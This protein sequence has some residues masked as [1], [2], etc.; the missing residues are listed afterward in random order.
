M[1]VQSVQQFLTTLRAT[2]ARGNSLDGLLHSALHNA[3]KYIEDNYN[4]KYMRFNTTIIMNAGSTSF[5]WSGDLANNLK[6]LRSLWSFDS[7][8]VR[9][10]LKQITPEA[11]TSNVGDSPVGFMLRSEQ[12]LDGTVNQI[13]TFD[14]SFKAPQTTLNGWGYVNRGWDGNILSQNVYLINRYEQ[15]VMARCMMQLAPVMRDQ[16]IL[17]MWG[18]LFQDNLQMLLQREDEFERGADGSE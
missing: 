7:N 6:V 10:N 8:G 14:T 13:I 12:Q 9:Q 15:L 16:A 3:L 5:T 2:H 18:S 17:T 11:W 4:L 1:P